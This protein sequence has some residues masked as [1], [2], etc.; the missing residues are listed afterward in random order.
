MLDL[1]GVAWPGAAGGRRGAL[2]RRLGGRGGLGLAAALDL[3]PGDL[4]GR[5]DLRL[6]HVAR[7]ALAGLGERRLGGGALGRLG[8]CALLLLAA[9]ALLGLALRLR[10]GL[11]TRLLLLAAEARAALLDDVADRVRDQRARP[12]RV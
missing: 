10:G 9:R 11:G 4:R 5:G 8:R 3:T 12:D 1:L 2:G 7:L 6:G